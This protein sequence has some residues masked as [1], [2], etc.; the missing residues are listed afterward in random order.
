[1]RTRNAFL[2]L[3]G[4][5][6]LGAQIPTFDSFHTT[7][8]FDGKP[9]KPLLR[10][11]VQKRFATQIREQAMLPPNFAG[12]YKIIE[13][14][15]GSSCVSIAI[16]DL[17]T[18]RVYDGPFSILGYGT[19]YK[20]EGGDDELQYKV[21]SRLLIAR[22]CPGDQNCGTYYYECKNDRLNQLR[23]VPHGPLQSGQKGHP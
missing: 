3:V 22:G 7:E 8:V 15:C 14:G 6:A 5:L 10:T 21:S 13:W 23:F 17:K 2:G 20:Y 12:H 1:M 16:V 11:P 4:A 9:A 19:P 18:G